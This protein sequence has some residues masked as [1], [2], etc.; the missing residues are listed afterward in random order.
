MTERVDA[1]VVG[2]GPNG[3]AAAVTLALAGLSVAVVE[4]SSTPG[5]GTRTAEL[6]QDGL[7]H[8]VC[9]AVHPLAVASPFLGSLPLHEHGLVWSWPAIDL[10]HPLD[11]GS[12]GVV[13]RD[14]D[15]TVGSLGR[16]GARWRDVFEP[17]ADQF[18]DLVSDVLRPLPAIPHH[19]VTLS[20]Y[21]IEALKPATR[22]ANRF[23]SE[24]ARALFAGSAAHLTGPLDRL[25]SASVGVLLTAAG[26]AGGWPVA[27]GGSATITS[28]LTS[29]LVSLGG[30]L[31]TGVEVRSMADLPACDVV[32]FD[33]SP[34]AATRIIGDQLPRGVKRSLKRWRYG[35]AAWK[36][37]LAVEG[38]IPWT[39]E[40]C[41][42]AGTVHVGG[43][44][45]EIARAEADV[46]AGRAADRP[47][48]LV[49]QQYLADPSRS[50]GNLHPVWAYAHVPHAYRGDATEPLL[51]QIERF[52]PGFRDRIVAT[53]VT[54]PAA[55]EAYNPN[56]VG[57]D[58]ATGANSLRQ[59]LARPRIAANPYRLGA[60]GLYLCSA[61]TPPGAGVHGM[62]GHL[63][64]QAALA[65]LRRRR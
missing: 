22:F 25:G 41:Q 7:L 63:A 39:A 50:K 53:H 30:K 3:L 1:V 17:L 35:P 2:S 28:A 49:A 10:A 13:S 15:V 44:M 36:V 48:V 40:A 12:A 38:G 61:A 65:D 24:A 47:F 55:L 54:G 62:C 26:H 59:L 64:A 18:T 45:A 16:D 42:L 46:A 52:A 9:S 14:L 57:G 34:H 60:D 6:T 21:G 27:V 11:N 5:G 43:T 23:H 4:A 32:L 56:Y 29:L 19:P 33:T 8:D 58:I 37:D 31:T 51:N 20:R